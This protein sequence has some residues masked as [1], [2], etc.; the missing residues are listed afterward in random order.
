MGSVSHHIMPLVLT[1]SGADTY[2]DVNTETI[3]RNQVKSGTMV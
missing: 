2:T 1:A 3:L